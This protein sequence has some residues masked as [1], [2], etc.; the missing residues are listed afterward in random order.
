MLGGE[1]E[2]LKKHLCMLTQPIGVKRSSDAASSSESDISVLFFK[3]LAGKISVCA[4]YARIR[5]SVQLM[6]P[7]T[8]CTIR[9]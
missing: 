5:G 8:K 2:L 6:I 4:R 7:E 1:L 9:F 3:P